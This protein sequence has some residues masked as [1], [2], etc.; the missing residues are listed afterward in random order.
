MTTAVIFSYGSNLDEAQMRARCPTAR[1]AGRATLRGHALT[2]GGYSHRWRGAVASVRRARGASVEGLL[3]ELDDAAVRLLDR[4]EGH[5]F[6]YQRVLRYPV[7][8]RGRR[9]RAQVYVQPEAGFEPWP[10]ATEYL[11]VILRAY[12]RLG[13]DRTVLAEAAFGA[14]P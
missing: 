12:G 14:A 5:P 10:P 2:F 8:E 4:F 7:D 6:A 1:L 13:F 9:R 11:A 3:Y